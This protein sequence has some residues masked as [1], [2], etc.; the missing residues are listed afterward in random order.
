[1]AKATLWWVIFRLENWFG[2]KAPLRRCLFR[3]PTASLR[4]RDFAVLRPQQCPGK[5]VHRFLRMRLQRSYWVSLSYGLV[6]F[7]A[8][9]WRS[10][11][12]VLPAAAREL[13]GDK[14]LPI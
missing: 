5:D 1:M 2:R 9:I 6:K 11:W 13:P 10:S 4:V 7:A 12:R 3:K 14:Y 8:L